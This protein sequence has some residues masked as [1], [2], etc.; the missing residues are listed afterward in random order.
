M[1]MAEWRSWIK[2]GVGRPR[3]AT[4]GLYEWTGVEETERAFEETERVREETKG[5]GREDEDSGI[6]I[7]WYS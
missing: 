1:R 6:G 5:A 4:E 3:G 2:E 7:G